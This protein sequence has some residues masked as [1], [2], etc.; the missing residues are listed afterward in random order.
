MKAK[1]LYYEEDK[2]DEEDLADSRQE[3]IEWISD[4]WCE[5]RAEVKVPYFMVS[6]PILLAQPRHE[7]ER[8]EE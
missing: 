5:Y 8:E 3:P 4:E 2:K 6:P 1:V 7:D